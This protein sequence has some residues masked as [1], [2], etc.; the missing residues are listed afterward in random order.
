MAHIVRTGVSK[1]KKYTQRSCY[2]TVKGT[3]EGV[4]TL[5]YL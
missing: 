3:D 1:V 2:H 5:L 4:G